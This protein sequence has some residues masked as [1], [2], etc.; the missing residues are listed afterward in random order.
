MN[1]QSGVTAD[2]KL[3]AVKPMIAGN[4]DGKKG[5]NA[6]RTKGLG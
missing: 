5:G 1:E 2:E 6:A 4:D 3:A